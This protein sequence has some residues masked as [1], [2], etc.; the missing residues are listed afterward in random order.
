MDNGRID[1]GDSR[2]KKTKRSSKGKSRYCTTICEGKQIHLLEIE[3][4]MILFRVIDSL[5]SLMLN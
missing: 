4:C 2:E 1:S 3:I 5:N